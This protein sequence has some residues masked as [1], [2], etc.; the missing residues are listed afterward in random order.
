MKETPDWKL[1]KPQYNKM[2]EVNVPFSHKCNFLGAVD[3][4]GVMAIL[5]VKYSQLR[6]VLVVNMDKQFKTLLH[7]KGGQGQIVTYLAVS[8]AL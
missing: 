8:Q 2:R 4:F 5:H 1:L 3:N 6:D 7:T